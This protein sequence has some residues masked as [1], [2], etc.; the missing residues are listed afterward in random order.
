MRYLIADENR[1]EGLSYDDARALQHQEVL[2][3]VAT[4]MVEVSWEE[5]EAVN[6]P[7]T[8]EEIALL[9]VGEK[10]ILGMCDPIERVA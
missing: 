8:M 2:G 4:K 3:E 1:F 6:D 5:L 10:T 7:E 9:K